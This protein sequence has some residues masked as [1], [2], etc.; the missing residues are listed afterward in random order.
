MGVAPIPEHRQEA[1]SVVKKGHH[2]EQQRIWQ[3]RGKRARHRIFLI[4]RLE[5]SCRLFSSLHF[6]ICLLL[7]YTLSIFFSHLHYFHRNDL[8]IKNPK[9]FSQEGKKNV[10]SACI[11]I[12]KNNLLSLAE[13]GERGLVGIDVGLTGAEA[14]VGLVGTKTSVG[15]TLLGLSKDTCT[16]S[17][18]SAKSRLASRCPESPSSESTSV[19]AGGSKCIVGSSERIVGPSKASVATGEGSSSS[20]S[21]SECRGTTVT[22]SATK[23]N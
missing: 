1:N 17:G 20:S 14:G 16:L 8:Y 9:T 23:M 2:Q 4:K 7:S 13:A 11:C 12:A 3:E 6:L 18:C 21:R 10:V 19:I 15:L 22:K 5:N